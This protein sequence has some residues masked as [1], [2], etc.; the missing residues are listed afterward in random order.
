MKRRSD[1]AIR[2][3]A[4]VH[5]YGTNCGQRLHAIASERGAEVEEVDADNFDGASYDMKVKSWV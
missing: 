5:V 4:F 2:G 3:E 1:A